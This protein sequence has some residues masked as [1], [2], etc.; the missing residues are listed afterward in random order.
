MDGKIIRIDP[1][2]KSNARERDLSP[3][4]RKMVD[5][6]IDTWDTVHTY[7]KTQCEFAT[8]IFLIMPLS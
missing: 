7:I 2:L 8:G 1:Y 5:E 4:L 3:A 6:L